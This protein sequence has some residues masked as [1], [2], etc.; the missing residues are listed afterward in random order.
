[1]DTAWF[2]WVA[3]LLTGA[4]SLIVSGHALLYKREARSALLW[5]LVTWFLPVLGPVL[6]L[7]IGINRL[8]RR[9]QRL[10]AAVAL[11]TLPPA[12]GEDQ[13]EALAD[14]DLGGLA[15][16][17]REVTGQP[18]LAGNHIEPLLNGEQTYPAML[19][20]IAQAQH[21]IALATYIFDREGIGELFV[22]ALLAAQRRGVSIRILIDDVYVRLVRGSAF[23]FLKAAGL[24]V[25]SFNPPVLPARLHAAN[26]RNHRKLL[27]VDG[28]VGFTGGMNIHRPYWKPEQPAQAFR[29]L[30]FRVEGPVVRHMIEAF[31]DDWYFTTQERLDTGFWGTNSLV[32]VGAALARGIEAGPDEML[33]RLRWVFLGALSVARQTVRI[34]TPYFVP[35]QSLLSAL[36]AAAL[37]GVTVDILTPVENNHPLVQ[38]AGR[39][40]YWQVLEHGARIWERPGPFDHSKLMVVDGRWLCLGS[41]NWDPRSLRLNFEFNLEVYD[42]ELAQ[43]MDALFCAVCQASIPVTAEALQARPLA[44]RLRDG[45]ARLL[46]PML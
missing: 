42:T 24:P 6:Y 19:D 39:A 10:R 9:A 32:P 11:P 36:S 22:E 34:W 1:M 16:L 46:S 23:K 33:E 29:E 17:V 2:E 4:T 5:L 21:S 35:D 37:R 7:L 30:H 41:A 43:R 45:A 25:V 13:T 26:L 31:T 12:A 3:L 27:I 38:W 15:R 18:L 8:Q 14:D 40:H 28:Q 44:V 20:A